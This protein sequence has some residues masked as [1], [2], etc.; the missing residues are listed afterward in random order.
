MAVFSKVMFLLISVLLLFPFQL[1][2]SQED[3]SCDGEENCHN[4][5]EVTGCIEDYAQLD[6]YISNNETL[7]RKFTETFFQTGESTYFTVC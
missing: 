2:S 4:D 6:L 5:L 1:C 3:V 7:L